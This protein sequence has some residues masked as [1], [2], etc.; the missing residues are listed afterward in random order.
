MLNCYLPFLYTLQWLQCKEN[1]LVCCWI[2]QRHPMFIGSEYDWTVTSW[3]GAEIVPY[4]SR[5]KFSLLPVKMRFFS[6][7]IRNKKQHF[8]PSIQHTDCCP[9]RR[10]FSHYMEWTNRFK[11][12]T[13]LQ[14]WLVILLISCLLKPLMQ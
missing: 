14:K 7:F 6:M 5:H 2:K 4:T 8:W 11:L 10:I 12:D 3:E 13:S 9:L 1:C